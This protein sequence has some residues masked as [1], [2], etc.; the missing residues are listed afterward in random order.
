MIISGNHSLLSFELF[1]NI[2]RTYSWM[3]YYN[4]EIESR[5]NEKSK[6]KTLLRVLLD[7]VTK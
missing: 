2:Q 7:D 5:D 4:S 6:E 3:K 1:K